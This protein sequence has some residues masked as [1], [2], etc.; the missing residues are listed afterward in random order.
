MSFMQKASPV[1]AASLALALSSR[2]N[3]NARDVGGGKRPLKKNV[4]YI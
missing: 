4:V 1:L 3:M 2:I